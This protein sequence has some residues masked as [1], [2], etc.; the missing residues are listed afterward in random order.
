MNYG[1]KVTWDQMQ[2]G[3]RFYYT[4]DMANASGNGV[5]T[6]K[7]P[8]DPR[9]NYKNVKLKWDDER[10]TFSFIGLESFQPG[11][12]RR[13]WLESDWEADRKRR[14]AE[15]TG[16]IGEALRKIEAQKQEVTG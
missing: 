10:E 13:F 9:W 5:I 12:G 2:P 1:P 14:I 11:P 15:M 7:L 8:I 3:V 6:E 16:P 4:G